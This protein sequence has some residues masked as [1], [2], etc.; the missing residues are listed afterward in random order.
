[1]VFSQRMQ[2]Y[3][4]VLLPLMGIAGVSIWAKMGIPRGWDFSY[5]T[6]LVLWALSG[7]YLCFAF[8]VSA[9]MI[10]RSIPGWMF[11][12]GDFI[13]RQFSFGM[14]PV[15]FALCRLALI[16]KPLSP[17]P[18]LLGAFAVGCVGMVVLMG[19]SM[20][21]S[22]LSS[23]EIMGSIFAL[24]A[25]V[26]SSLLVGSMIRFSMDCYASVRTKSARGIAIVMLMICLLLPF[27]GLI[28]N[29]WI[30]FPGSFQDP[31]VWVLAGINGIAL[32]LPAF[33]NPLIHRVVWL[34][35][36]ACFS[37]TLYFFLVF[38]PV[39]PLAPLAV[40]IM[41]AGFLIL[42]PT[43]LFAVHLWR[44]CD[45]WREGKRPSS[46]GF[47]LATAGMTAALILP[48]TLA[49]QAHRDKVALDQAVAYFQSPDFHVNSRFPNDPDA[50]A[51]LL[52][53][54]HH[55]RNGSRLPLIDD[56]YQRVVL[57]G[58]V[59]PEK[60]T[61]HLHTQL[62]G[63]PP[64]EFVHS[65][66]MLW[67][68]PRNRTFRPQATLPPNPGMLKSAKLQTMEIAPH[69]ARSTLQ[70]AFEN[71]LSEVA[72]FSTRIALAEGTH[73][74][75]YRLQIGDEWVEGRLFDEKTA[76]WLYEKIRQQTA[77]ID[78]GLL[79]IVSAGE[80]D[81]R[82]FPVGAKESR[83]TEIILIHPT[84]QESPARV[85]SDTVPTQM[86]H[87]NTPS[88]HPEKPWI[89]FS[90]EG[91]IASVPARNL[92]PSPA[93]KPVVLRIFEHSHSTPFEP[94]RAAAWLK[95]SDPEDVAYIANFEVA[96]L[97][98]QDSVPPFPARGS[99]DAPRAILTALNDF[100]AS[101]D[102]S[103]FY[104][105]VVLCGSTS[106]DSE[107][108]QNPPVATRMTELA[109]ESPIVQI[110]ATPDDPIVAPAGNICIFRLGGQIV[111]IPSSQNTDAQLWVPFPGNLQPSG[112]SLPHLEVL[113]STDRQ[114]RPLAYDHFDHA[115]YE[116][117]TEAAFWARERLVNPSHFATSLGTW[118]H[119]AK[120]LG[121]LVPGLAFIAAETQAQWITLARKES[122]KAEKNAAFEIEDNTEVIPE[123]STI[124]LLLLAGLYVI[125]RKWI[126]PR[127]RVQSVF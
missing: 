32:S 82:V 38:L 22:M 101:M 100:E 123:P 94:M 84:G 6:A 57:G 25:L 4:C 50:A 117:A 66:T 11:G 7:I 73:I 15:L 88:T 47:G 39:I 35:Q 60:L 111:A 96:E 95:K 102:L 10:P 27:A 48:V 70:I 36:C 108:F 120:E 59:L 33:R 46:R 124:L 19:I 106:I 107:V 99:F 58:L 44:V 105:V 103:K 8:S 65:F 1:M 45:G 51:R 61:E 43:M 90:A 17:I 30:P 18:S 2:G 62:T 115:D 28:L 9:S 64:P 92:K 54:I 41:G 24:A 98:E 16:G 75:G 20:L 63:S 49:I 77:P 52:T 114:W 56:Y 71:P 113:D 79:R 91:S 76:T 26:I 121:V 126:R 37:F 12:P 119:R 104:P 118:L 74:T 122:D 3:L 110:Q 86:T 55:L 87:L 97:E 68:P 125:Y 116:R 29:T 80:A 78:P 112:D 93:R 109:P 85:V 14:I 42:V 31:I 21:A 69:I 5:F 89:V 127:T 81:L 83:L 72:E 53:K 67:N 23:F 13:F 34:A 40:P